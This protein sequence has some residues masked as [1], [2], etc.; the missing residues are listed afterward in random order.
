MKSVSA[1][2]GIRSPAMRRARTSFSRF[3]RASILG[4][5]SG[6]F[7]PSGADFPRISSSSEIRRRVEARLVEAGIF[8]GSSVNDS[9]GCFNRTKRNA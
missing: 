3:E 9:L 7:P 8:E 5:L 2:A 6:M 1:I 4:C